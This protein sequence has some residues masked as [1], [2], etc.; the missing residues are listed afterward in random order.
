M[1]LFFT[2]FP[3]LLYTV[4]TKIKTKLDTAARLTLT[5]FALTTSIRTAI[6]ILVVANQLE[7]QTSFVLE[8]LVAIGGH[9]IIL[10]L[11]YFTFELEV[12]MIIVESVSV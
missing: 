2:F 11:Y 8:F 1:L 10:S 7:Q 6:W 3:L 12:S 5:C 4:C 9:I